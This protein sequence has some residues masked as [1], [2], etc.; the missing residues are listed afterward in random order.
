MED[1]VVPA[2]P[3]ARPGDAPAG[4]GT[5]ST[6]GTSETMR[7]DPLERLRTA[8][9]AREAAGLRRALRPRTPTHDGLIDVASN[10]YLGLSRDPRLIEAAVAAVR[11]WGAGSTGSRLVTGST[12]LHAELEERLAAFARAPRALVFSSGYLAN[13]AAVATLGAGGLVVSDE[14]NHASI[15][16]ACRLSRA[17]VA[18]TPHN[19]P[20]AV[21]KALAAREEEHAVVVTDAVFSVDGDLAPIAELHEVASRHGA[22]LIVDEAHS[23]GVVGEDGR[24]AVHAA[25]LADA[26][27]IV[28]TV[29]LSKSLGA[30]GGAVLGAPEIVDTLVDTGRAFIFD[31]GLAPASVASALAALDIVSGHPDLPGRARGNAVAL[32]RAVRERGLPTLEPAAAVVRV[33]LGPPDAALAAAAV[34]AEHGVRAGCFRPPS[35]PSGRSC[36]RLTA[37][38]NLSSDDLAVIGRALTAV[39]EMK[40]SV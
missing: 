28:R 15:I 27:D 5:Y 10:D 9:A 33:V 4:D 22:L 29:T 30:Q 12:R 36:L 19:D 13:L 37:R 31:T 20:A 14:G 18:V 8:A 6:A 38:A 2:G 35:V 21:G 25:G 34:F 16:D 7:T 11:R 17:R 1:N 26:P 3:V 39:A 23:L 32:A 40:V 24:G